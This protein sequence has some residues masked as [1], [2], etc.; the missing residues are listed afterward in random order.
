MPPKP[1]PPVSWSAVTTI[2]VSVRFRAQSY[3]ASIASSKARTSAAVHAP[4]REWPAQSICPASTIRKNPSRVVGQHVERGLRALRDRGVLAD[5]ALLLAVDRVRQG[6]RSHQAVDGTGPA[7]RRVGLERLQVLHVGDGRVA[8]E[9][10][11][12]AAP[13]PTEQVLD[14]VRVHLGGDLLVLTAVGHVRGEGAR[15]RVGQVARA[16]QAGRLAGGLGAL[17][18]GLARTSPG[19]GAPSTP[20]RSASRTRRRAPWRRPPSR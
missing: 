13:T 12:R 8:L 16:E 17:Q 15:R 2:S 19:A 20:S 3:A 1:S 6:L 18:H 9:R 4:S 14:V 10:S 11:D 5:G 7:P